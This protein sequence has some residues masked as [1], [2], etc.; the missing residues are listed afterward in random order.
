LQVLSDMHGVIARDKAVIWGSALLAPFTA[1]RR[2]DGFEPPMLLDDVN[3]ILPGVGRFRL[4]GGSDDIITVLPSREPHVRRVIETCLRPGDT[5]VDAGANLGLFSVIAHQQV[6]PEGRIIAVEMIPET[7][8]ILRRHL[9]D[10]G[11]ANATIIE[12]ALSDETGK[13][14]AAIAL[15]YKH[16]QASIAAATEQPKG[17]RKI[18]VKSIRLDEVLADCPSIGLIK[19]DLEGAELGALRGAVQILDRVGA[20]VFENN[21]ED[22][23]IGELLAAHRFKLRHLSGHDYLAVRDAQ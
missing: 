7:A 14:L 2:L 5:F 4:R 6:G 17:S 3:V 18:A 16:G 8:A 11:V 19:M 23:R 20:I 22:P 21:R 12:R 9:Q 15:E 1:L 10:N 13:E